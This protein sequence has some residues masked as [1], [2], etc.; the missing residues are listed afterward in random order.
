[1]HCPELLSYVHTYMLYTW[2]LLAC[3]RSTLAFSGLSLF[4]LR[5]LRT[6]PAARSASARFS[7]LDKDTNKFDISKDVFD[8][9][10]RP[11]RHP[12]ITGNAR[13]MPGFSFPAPRNLESIVKYALLERE[14][15]SEIKMIWTTFHDSRKDCVASVID[16]ATYGG[17]RERAAK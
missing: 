7:T 12:Y 3:M 4:A 16:G 6:M 14:A 11:K 15:P 17:F 8:P 13:Y 1:M 10:K 5:A 2:F 9:L